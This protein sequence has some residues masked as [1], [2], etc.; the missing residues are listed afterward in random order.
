VVDHEAKGGEVL[1]SEFYNEL[2]S[3]DMATRR[4]F[5]LAL[6][7]AAAPA[8]AAAT[9]A[10][11]TAAAPAPAALP[12]AAPAAPAPATLEASSAAH[13]AAAHIQ[14]HFRGYAVRKV[15]RVYR[16]GGVV[17]EMLYA[18]ALGFAPP[19]GSPAPFGRISAAMAVIGNTLWLY[20]GMLEVGDK[21]ITCDDLWSLDLNKLAAWECAHVG[22]VTREELRAAEAGGGAASSDGEWGTDDEEDE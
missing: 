12:P 6:R 1:I 8:A 16:I 9:A 4:W 18:P 21:E 19:R 14:A 15:L 11:A 7:G 3:F 17:S 5:P 10:A 20:G 22:S 2:Y 13:R